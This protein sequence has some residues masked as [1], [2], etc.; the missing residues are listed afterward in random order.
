M[1][2]EIHVK[3]KILIQNNVKQLGSMYKC[4]KAAFDKFPTNSK[5]YTVYCKEEV[6]EVVK[7]ENKSPKMFSCY[8]LFVNEGALINNINEINHMEKK[9]LLVLVA[10][11][12]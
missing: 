1:L 10:A 3:S 11:A 2:V 7:K 4:P 5:Y 12:C 9:L 8:I 6:E